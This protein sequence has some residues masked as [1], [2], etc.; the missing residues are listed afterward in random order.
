MKYTLSKAF[1]AKL[2]APIAD[3]IR[4]WAQT[5][6]VRT[7]SVQMR[8]KVYIEE[9]A[10]YTAFSLDCTAQ[11]TAR[12][13]G[14]W[15][16]ASGL[17]PSAECAIPPGCTLVETGFFMGKAYLNVNHNDSVPAMAAIQDGPR[18]LPQAAA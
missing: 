18:A 17:R 12:A 14:E 13:A 15:A 7:V 4:A 9:D 6:H 11:K 10:A 1:Y 8:A 5:H 3:H 16:G 2:P